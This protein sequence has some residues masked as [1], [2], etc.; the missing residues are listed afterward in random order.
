MSRKTLADLAN[1][2]PH[3]VASR[4][5]R[6]D[7]EALMTRPDGVVTVDLLAA[8]AEHANGDVL[9]L[10]L[11]ARLVDWLKE[12]LAKAGLA[13]LDLSKAELSIAIRTN[14]VPTDR[15]KTVPF[16][17]TSTAS[18]ATGAKAH[19]SK[20]TFALRWYDRQTGMITD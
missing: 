9:Q 17:F 6:D 10:A 16:E 8:R 5:D 12:R 19:T 13:P 14:R 18:F 2:M 3:M 1:T 15:R 20:P 4:I 11:V 7:L